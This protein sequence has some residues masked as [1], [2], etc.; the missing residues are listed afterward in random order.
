MQYLSILQRNSG[1]DLIMVEFYENGRLMGKLSPE[2]FMT[3]GDFP[4]SMFLPTAVEKWNTLYK[5]KGRE[6]KIV[7]EDSKKKKKTK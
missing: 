1:K 7:L 2:Q 6:V 4:K 5:S 3:H